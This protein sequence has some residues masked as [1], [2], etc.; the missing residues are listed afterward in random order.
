M[1]FG[2][3]NETPG[4]QLTP[5]M[6]QKRRAA[7]SGRGGGVPKDIGS[8]IYAALTGLADGIESNRLSAAESAGKA[9]GMADFQS[10]FGFGGG[11]S[12]GGD[13]ATYSPT[14]APETAPSGGGAPV[15]GYE[16]PQ[17]R[18]VYDAAVAQG[19][20]PLQAAAFVGAGAL[21]ES[22]L[23]PNAR[24]RGD[25]RDG[26]DSVGLFQW[27]GP[28]ARALQSYAAEQGKPWNDP[29][30]QVG[31]AL[32][33]L[34]TSE[35]RAGQL[36]RAAQTPEQA[37]G[38]MLHYLRPAGF[39]PQNP[40]GVPSS[41]ARLKNT[42]QLYNIFG[43]RAD[44]GDPGMLVGPATAFNED[45]AMLVNPPQGA[46]N[47][48]PGIMVDPYKP[49][50]VADSGQI[51][52]DASPVVPQKSI[53]L[54]PEKPQPPAPVGQPQI[55]LSAFPKLQSDRL[56]AINMPSNADEQAKII[57]PAL[58][59]A[60]VP[61]AR[62]QMPVEMQQPRV[63]PATPTPAAAQAPAA[64]AGLQM[65]QA[66]MMM[67]LRDS[68]L[69]SDEQNAIRARLFGGNAP[70][71]N[72]AAPTLANQPQGGFL[73]RI[74]GG[75]QQSQPAP[76]NAPVSA[77]QGQPAASPAQPAGP[78]A[79]MQQRQPQASAP[80][81]Q[82]TV[83]NAALWRLVNNPFAPEAARKIA[84]Q[85]LTADPMEAEKNRL[86][87]ESL[88]N[89]NSMFPLQRQQAELG[90]KKS[91]NELQMTPQDRR[92]RELEIA[93]QE[94][95]LAGEGAT[96]LTPEERA[97]YGIPNEQSAYKTR[98][99]EIKFGPAAAKTTVN[100]DNRQESEFGKETGK[101]I[102]KRFDEMAT[103][104]DEA[105]QNQVLFDELRRLGGKIKT[106]ASAALT[107]RLGDIGVKLDGAS[108]VEAYGALIDR[109]T[110]AQRIPGSGPTS[111]FDA[112]MFKGSLPKLMN[113][114]EGNA[115]ILDTMQKLNDNKMARGDIAMRAQI[116]E[117]SPKEAL[118]E[119]RKLQLEARG[120][121]DNVKN[122]GKP[123]E[124][125]TQIAPP[126]V[127]QNSIVKP[128]ANGGFKILKV[129]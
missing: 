125:G 126:T 67:L 123:K 58:A 54:M 57:D 27:N 70:I 81:Q 110:P 26:S 78:P 37:V 11:A 63:I 44:A 16:N 40:F 89:Q 55:D 49:I 100:L 66:D 124:S 23:N 94:R 127:D 121:S 30:V 52:N 91:E 21:P 39:T 48:D 116:G 102:S 93:Q 122:F 120:L 38:A 112:T 59:N 118:V 4:D 104:G 47:G 8:G 82:P 103:A 62:P 36:L 88:R 31:F 28:R 33:E 111:D 128:P 74:F 80:A 32:R 24:N 76:Q 12:G 13:T 20:S 64:P 90:V 77:P 43:R 35:G 114:P 87:L 34:N 1:A 72:T 71:A 79:E 92:K 17:S 18:A 10:A 109:L 41:A 105:A 75:Q 107:K 2:F 9:Q 73:S 56:A 46:E 65:S 25:G 53:Q 113:T 15:K 50:R 83:D 6:I 117:L 69:G 101:A 68:S 85:K 97:Q 96:P 14:A 51:M 108:D 61:M 86:Q 22:S 106:G 5:E 95:N 19:L 98:N 29:T 119:L 42:N 60:P 3:F 84:L 115:L 7:M 45:P 99:G 129:E